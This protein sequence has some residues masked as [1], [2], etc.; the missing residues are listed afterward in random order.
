MVEKLA[1]VLVCDLDRRSRLDIKS[2][3]GLFA[4]IGIEFSQWAVRWAHGCNWHFETEAS[5]MSHFSQQIRVIDGRELTNQV[6]QLDR[7]CHDLVG[8]GLLGHG[9][10]RHG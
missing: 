5:K 3:R 4:L 7:V 9:S 6:E 2:A 10:I 1:Q 8:H